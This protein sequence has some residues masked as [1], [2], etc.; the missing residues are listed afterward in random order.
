MHIFRLIQEFVK[1]A[2]S[3]GN[4]SSVKIKLE[5]HKNALQLY[6]SDNGKGYNMES[7]LTGLGTE[8]A[9]NRVQILG[10]ALKIYS[11]LG[12]G[13]QWRLSLPQN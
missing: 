9:R 6:L 4:A 12:K 3:H 13:V 2:I 1:N 10:G 5:H 11:E 8:S 7:T